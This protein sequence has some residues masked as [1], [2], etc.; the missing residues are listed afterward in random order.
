MPE[1]HTVHRVA[2]QINQYFAGKKPTLDSPQGRFARES[3]LLSGRKLLQADAFG[4]QLLVDYGNLGLIR[5]HLGIYGKWQFKRVQPGANGLTP[6]GQVRLRL[7][8]EDRLAELR[9]PTVCELITREQ[10]ELLLARLGPDPLRAD[11]DGSQEQR[12]VDRVVRSNLG[13]ARLLMDQSVI[14]GVGNV[15]RAELLFRAQLN[16]DV[17]GKQLPQELLR[18]IWRDAVQLLAAGRKTGVMVT[19]DDLLGKVV[20]V[21]DRNFVYRRAGEGCRVCG[22][23]VQMRLEVGRK[24]Y[25]CATCQR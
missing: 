19:R 4:K 7:L 9:G 5:V 2:A 25:W 20:P 21:A 13:I 6:I 16:P 15:Y 18:T 12:F 10:S 8:A 23:K 14:A 3:A 17:P 11:L 24:L 1:G 22:S